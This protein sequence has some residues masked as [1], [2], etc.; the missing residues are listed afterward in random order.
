MEFSINKIMFSEALSFISSIVPERSARP[1]LQNLL[2]ESDGEAGIT[3]SATDLEISLRIHL[4]VSDLK[5]PISVLLPAS[6]LN[7]IVKGIGGDDLKLEIEDLKLIVK[8]KFGRFQ[9]PGA[10]VIDYPAI[11]DF[12]SE[13]AIF[14]H[15]DDFNDAVQKNIF[16]TA[17]GDTRYALN[18]IFLN[19]KDN[20]C[21]FV[22]SDTHR[23]SLVKK[24]IRNPDASVSEGIILTK[25]MNILS[26]LAIGKD[27]IE[28]NITPNE[29]LA[30]TP[31]ATL[32]VRRVEGMFPRYQDV[33]PPKSDS[34]F[35]VNR[36]ELIKNLHSIGLVASEETRAIL[37]GVSPGT[38]SLSAKS[39]NGEGIVILD[40]EV[41]GDE[42]EI[43]FNYQFVI[44]AL[45]AIDDET[46][47]MQYNGAENPARIDNGDFLYVIMPINR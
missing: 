44:D 22:A 32:A 31:T 2:L 47:E 20:I 6:R 17:K 45:K 29:L 25:G 38:L 8:T 14:I 15:G 18:G 33:I 12:K 13:G 34:R 28:I 10:D 19:I 5:D 16:A 4:E 23:L 41:R 21:D 24:K 11:S 30:R 1:V 37:F 35:V 42:C 27:V 40:A 3:L 36:D 39:E 9:L 46:V 26:R 7:A 43:K